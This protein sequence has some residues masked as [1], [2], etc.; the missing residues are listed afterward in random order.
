MISGPAHADHLVEAVVEADCQ[1]GGRLLDLGPTRGG[2]LLVGTECRA[3]AVDGAAEDVGLAVDAADHRRRG[4]VA[5]RRHHGTGNPGVGRRV[6]L[7]GE[8]LGVGARDVPAED[9]ELAVEGGRRRHLQRHRQRRPG[10]PAAGGRVEGL[11]GGRP[12]PAAAIRRAADRIELAAERR[13]GE[14]DAGGR[15]RRGRGPGVGRGIVDLQGGA[16]AAAADR[17]ELAAEGGDGQAV[18]RRRHGSAGGPGVGRRLV[19][20]EQIAGEGA[21]REVDAAVAGR[22][23]RAAE[24]DGGDGPAFRP[25]VG[26]RVEDLHQGLLER[27]GVKRRLEAGRAA[28]AEG[29]D[30]PTLGG[31]GEQAARRRQAPPGPPAVRLSASRLSRAQRGES[32]Q[33]ACGDAMSHA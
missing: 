33:R 32:K 15:H 22:R 24:E 20:E 4:L 12:R 31:G 27:R 1:V 30:P 19:G 8:A 14:E 2:V 10:L 18:A 16:G 28:A 9:V 17:V 21:A 25:G 6:V 23:R 26:G 3:V 11:D 13:G 29:V 5:R 7:E